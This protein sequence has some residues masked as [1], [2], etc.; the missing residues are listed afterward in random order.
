MRVAI[1]AETFL[2]KWDGVANTVCHLLEYLAANG[3]ESLMIAPEGATKEYTDEYARAW[4]RIYAAV[5]MASSRVRLRA[6]SA[7]RN[8]WSTAARVCAPV[9][10]TPFGP[11]AMLRAS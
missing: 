9:A 10:C 3:H 2:P 7:A 4:E 11:A 5:A 6:A 1:F 8:I